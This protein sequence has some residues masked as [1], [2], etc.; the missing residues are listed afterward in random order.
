VSLADDATLTIGMTVF[1]AE[2]TIARA[3]RSVQAQTHLEWRLIVLDDGSHDGTARVVQ[4]LA[5]S[6]DRIELIHGVTRQGL[7]HRLNQLIDLATST[8]F[9]RMDADDICHPERFAR[10]LAFMTRHPEV[11]LVGSSMVILGGD[12]RVR[13]LRRAPARHDEICARP[14]SS[15][16]LFHPTW[17]GQRLWFKRFGY[18]AH[19]RRCEDQELLLRAHRRSR[20]ANLPE[21][22]LGYSEDHLVWHHIQTGRANYAQT[23][24]RDSWRSGHVLQPL[25]I[26]LEHAAKAMVETIAITTHMEHRLLRHRARPLAPSEIA[27]WERACADAAAPATSMAV[28]A[29]ESLPALSA[30]GRS[31]VR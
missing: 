26:A 7:P 8:F 27:E 28:K 20:F 18:A 4:A 3:V 22:L 19:A 31:R 6:D 15:F 5:E 11:E 1:N 2:R 25:T 30:D 24:M 21:P 29:A 13:G 17:L 14:Y 16:P 12:G 10:Q 9:A 23:A